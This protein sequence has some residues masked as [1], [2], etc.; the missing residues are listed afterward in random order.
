MNIGKWLMDLI[1]GEPV[2][3]LIPIRIID[4]A[5]EAEAAR[6]M[7]E[8]QMLD[9]QLRDAHGTETMTDVMRRLRG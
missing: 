1:T 4:R 8:R 3:Q 7:I 9:R 6:Q 5:S 2:P